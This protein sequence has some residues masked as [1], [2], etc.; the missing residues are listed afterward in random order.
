[1]IETVIYAFSPDNQPVKKAKSGET[2]HFKTKD[3]FSDKICKETDL[4][5][6]FN[7]DQ[8]NPAS[9]PVYIEDAEPGDIL[10]VD[11]LDIH[12]NTQGVIATLPGCGPLCDTQE[13]R[14]KVIPIRNGIAQFNHI[15]FPIEPMIGVIG[16]A[17]ATG[18]ISCGLPG[19]HGGNMDCHLIRK[20]ARLY[21]PVNVKGALFAL[22]DLHAAMGD[23][24]VCGTGLE[25]AGEVTTKVTLLKQ[26][27]L[28]WP[29]LETEDAW[30]VIANAEIYPEA[31]KLASLEMQRLMVAAYAWDLTDCY[32]Y[33][34]VQGNVEIC[35]A[36]KPCFIDLIVRIGIPKQSDQ[37]LIKQPNA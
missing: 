30:Y 21:F 23:G 20:G 34:S 3:C 8:A 5:T 1:M 19:S 36:C 22:G 12:V 28:A 10:V 11:I 25:I 29:V 37:P 18:K 7:Y 16:V 6:D 15:S 9:G 14:T 24:E 13:T 2:L 4:V 32:L 17:P 27:Q 31:L 35:Q 26:T 33:L